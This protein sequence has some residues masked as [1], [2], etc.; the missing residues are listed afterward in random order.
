MDQGIRESVGR[1][2]G[3]Q[4]IRKPPDILVCDILATGLSRLFDLSGPFRFSGL[5]SLFRFSDFFSFFSPFA[6]ADIRL[7]C[8]NMVGASRFERPVQPPHISAAC[9]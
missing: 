5:F 4:V 6:L 3:Y 8:L 9:Q 1:V 2:S 7:L